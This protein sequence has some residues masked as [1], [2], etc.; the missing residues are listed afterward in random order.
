MVEFIAEIGL[1]HNGDIFLAKEMVAAAKEARADAVKFQSIQ[2]EKLL[3]PQTLKTPIDGF[4]IRGVRTLRDFWE[5]VSIDFDF[6]N[7]INEYCRKI[8]IEF[9]ST[10]FDLPSVDLLEK[11]GVSRFKV[12]SG[13]INYLPLLEHIAAKNKPILLSCGASTMG[14]IE[15]TVDFL[16]ERSI[17]ITLLHCVS[18][19]PTPV[20][21][22]NLSVIRLLQQ[23]FNLPVGFS[24]HTIGYHTAL[25]AI[26]CGAVVIEKHFTIDRSLPGP[27][28]KFSA[29]P[30]VF[31]K[32]VRY[33][34]Q[35]HSACTPPIHR[36][37]SEENSMRL[38]M[39]R[40][41]VAAK[42]LPA[43]TVLSSQDLDCKR[44]QTGI[45]PISFNEVL[46]KRLN[47]SV[48][49]NE[50]ILWNYLDD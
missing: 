38:A 22:A 48:Q 29:D 40:G 50:P 23:I 45:S 37:S 34:R 12:A 20:E 4:G 21:K 11:I 6:H 39:R 33:G 9:L 18:L 28:Q 15:A 30:K 31:E 32:L 47:R 16:Q 13:D 46:G 27:D 49:T 17:S 8:E 24:D 43:G 41:I 7:E 14:E 2:A 1:N 19:Y 25:G 5:K 26:A 10:P 3:N 36:I 35:L 42:D 44:P